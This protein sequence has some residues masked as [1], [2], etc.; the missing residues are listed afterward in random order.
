MAPSFHSSTN[1]VTSLAHNAI[2]ATNLTGQIAQGTGISNRIGDSVRLQSLN[3]KGYFNTDTNAN[4]YTY[5]L[6]L[7]Y[8]REQVNFSTFLVNGLTESNLFLPG[9]TGAGAV[10]GVV[11]TKVVSV[12]YDETFVINSL[13]TG[14]ADMNA[15][16]RNI[17][18][19]SHFPYDPSGSVFGKF[20]NLYL[21]TTGTT[22][23][24]TAGTP[25]G[26]LVLST[27]LVFKNP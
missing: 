9:T 25:L 26:R 22:I 17:A 12:L 24:S 7:V 10:N 20:K 3:I 1:T 18:I 21:V 8:S 15:I 19:N 13:V 23:T 6:M 11:N 4:A 16:A 27:D 2:Y 14:A 5:R